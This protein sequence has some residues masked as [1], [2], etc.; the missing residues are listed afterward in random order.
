MV[1]LSNLPESDGI[2]AEEL[3]ISVPVVILFMER[4]CSIDSN[5][6]RAEGVGCILYF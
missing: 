2:G 5:Q 4:S 3:L 6:Y 1:S